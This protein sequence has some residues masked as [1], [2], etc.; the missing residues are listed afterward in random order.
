MKRLINYNSPT[1]HSHFYMCRPQ[2]AYGIEWLLNPLPP[3]QSLDFFIAKFSIQFLP[4]NFH[5]SNFAACFMALVICCCD[6]SL[7]F[8]CINC[9][10]EISPIRTNNFNSCLDLDQACSLVN[11]HTNKLV[12]LFTHNHC[13]NM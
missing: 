1:S 12:L 8:C 5:P 10:M 13:Y 11:K 3:P 4:F 9:K 6:F 2:A 7:K